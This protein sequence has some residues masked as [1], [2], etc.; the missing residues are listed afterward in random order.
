[1][2]VSSSFAEIVSVGSSEGKPVPTF[3]A[4]ADCYV[5][6]MIMMK[7]LTTHSSA[8]TDGGLDE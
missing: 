3:T 2:L 5:V 1:M 8:M 7:T 4:I 6:K